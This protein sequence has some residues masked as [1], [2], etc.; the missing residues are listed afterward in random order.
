[1]ENLFKKDLYWNVIHPK[2]IK[3]TILID[4]GHGGLNDKEIY[5]TPGKR[6]RHPVDGKFWYEGH[7]MR[8][9]GKEWAKIL[10]SFGYKVKFVVDP[11]DYTDV[12]L[13]QRS[14]IANEL[15]QKEYCILASLHTN[16]DSDS[17]PRPGAAH[18]HEVYTSPGITPSDHWAKFWIHQFKRS[19]FGDTR[20][21]KDLSDGFPDKEA[22][23]HMVTRTA[24]PAILLEMDFH[25]NDEAVRR[26]RL[27][28]WKFKSALAFSRSCN[29][30]TQYLNNEKIIR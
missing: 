25:T 21:R 15:H 24:M 28:N 29:M 6:S 1:M 14:Q 20:I 9:L 8:I 22:F 12:P 2:L 17:S 23:F 16:A 11:D 4:C 19:Y 13:R 7:E 5:V 27:W 10:R 26:M 3:P 30:F 18:G